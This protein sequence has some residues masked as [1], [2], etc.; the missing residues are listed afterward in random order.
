MLNLCITPFP[1]ITE[2]TFG[3]DGSVTLTVRTAH[4]T[5]RGLRLQPQ[6]AVELRNH[7]MPTSLNFG[8]MDK[9]AGLSPTSTTLSKELPG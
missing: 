4:G 7:L 8:A 9:P 5:V 2:L 1:E 6:S 3:S